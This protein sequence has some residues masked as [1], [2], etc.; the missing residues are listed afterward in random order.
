MMKSFD[1][2]REC[3]CDENLKK[4]HLGGILPTDKRKAKHVDL[5]TLPKDIQGTNCGNCKYYEKDGDHGYCKHKE[6]EMHVT[7]RQCCAKWTATGAFRA[8]EK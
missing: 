5:I 3:A 6:V 7:A 2:W 1:Q 4:D 8:W